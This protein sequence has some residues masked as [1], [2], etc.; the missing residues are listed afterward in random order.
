V[1]TSHDWPWPSSVGERHFTL[2]AA[3]MLRSSPKH[4]RHHSSKLPK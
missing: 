1:Q 2:A 3:P 4:V